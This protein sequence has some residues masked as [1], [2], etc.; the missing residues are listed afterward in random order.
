MNKH[1]LAACGIDCNECGSYKVTIK[2]D[3][4]AAEGLVEWSRSR[5]WIG[6][7]EGAE[8]VLK[9]AKISPICLGCWDITADCLWQC[10][11]GSRDFRVCCKKKQINHCGECGGFPR[12]LLGMG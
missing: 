3:M 7:N 6:E 11:C 9:K 1:K 12:T 2:Q 10:G 8:A 5:G 4:K